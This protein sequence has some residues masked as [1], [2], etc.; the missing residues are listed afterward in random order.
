MGPKPDVQGMAAWL[1]DP[2]NAEPCATFPR[3]T[4]R[5]AAPGLYAWHG[6]A[7]ANEI[8][9]RVLGCP[10]QPLY[11]DQAGSDSRTGKRAS[12]ATMKSAI[13]RHHL[14]GNTHASNLRRSL[15][16]V[17]WH[18][19][20]LRCD[21]PKYLDAESNARLSK[22]MLDH[23]SVAT[24][25]IQDR[26]MLWLLADDLRELLDPGLNLV[27]NR[28]HT[29]GRHKLLALRTQH[30]SYRSAD[31]S[32]ADRLLDLRAFAAAQDTGTEFLQ[33]RLAHEERRLG[34]EAA[35]A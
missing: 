14:N 29:A 25:A 33:R 13:A 11:V 19:L 4:M 30:F 34:K 26:G 28:P 1:R 31:A 3:V 16:A 21:R 22:W 12:G 17:L 32:R 20:S 6:D 8:I 24:V 18:E 35:S 7:V 23:L 2:A 9:G 10:L 27:K 5:V 15:G